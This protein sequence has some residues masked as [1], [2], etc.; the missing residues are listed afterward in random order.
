MKFWRIGQQL[1]WMVVEYPQELEARIRYRTTIWSTYEMGV[2]I[3]NK[4]KQLQQKV[5]E[6]NKNHQRIQLKIKMEVFWKQLMK[7]QKWKSERMEIGI[8]D[9]MQPRKKMVEDKEIKQRQSK[10]W[11][12]LKLQVETMEQQHGK[13]Y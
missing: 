6:N 11:D 3:Q 5:I 12:H 2:T 4:K 10:V 1:D 8:R 9:R 7:I 13:E